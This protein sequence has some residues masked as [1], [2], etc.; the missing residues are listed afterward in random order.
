MVG[1]SLELMTELLARFGGL[2]SADHANIA[3]A[4]LPHLDDSRALIR[5]RALHCLGEDTYLLGGG[6][7]QQECRELLSCCG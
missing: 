4:V 6:G 5:K 3:A 1:D 2:L 7:E